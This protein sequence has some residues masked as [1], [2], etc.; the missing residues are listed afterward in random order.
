MRQLSRRMYVK[1]KPPKVGKRRPRPIMPRNIYRGIRKRTRFSDK[2]MDR[3]FYDKVSETQFTHVMELFG[4][5][6]C[7][8]LLDECINPVY[9]PY[10]MALA[11]QEIRCDK[12]SQ[13]NWKATWKAR[14]EYDDPEIQV[15]F[16]N[17]ERML[18][19]IGRGFRGP[20]FSNKVQSTVIVCQKKL[21]TEVM[22]RFV[23]NK[24]F[25]FIKP[26]R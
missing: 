2:P 22:N 7:H 26:Q 10:G 12:P 16:T 20:S 14:E 25:G 19:P 23:N 15:L 21:Y 8:M 1:Y 9:L 6:I 24:V 11:L 17:Y 13:V 5:E 3:M 18:R 4:E